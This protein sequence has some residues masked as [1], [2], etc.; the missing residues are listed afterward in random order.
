MSIDINKI[1][2]EKITEM[3]KNGEIKKHLEEKLQKLILDSVSSA[4]SGY[5]VQKKIKEKIDIKKTLPIFS[6]HSENQ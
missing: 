3:E 5:D 6:F 1:A 4:L 2:Q